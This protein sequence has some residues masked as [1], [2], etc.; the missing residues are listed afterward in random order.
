MS[1]GVEIDIQS[2]HEHFVK[3]TNGYTWTLLSKEDRSAEENIEMVYAANASLYHGTQAGTALHLQ[4][5]GWL[6]AH[7]YTILGYDRAALRHAN[8]CLELA[9]VNLDMMKD[10]DVAY[11]Y[12]GMARALALAG[13]QDKAMSYYEKVRDA[14]ATIGDEEDHSIFI[15]DFESG[16]WYGIG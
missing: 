2:A 7:V 1:E 13:I 8:R 16:D 9:Q 10:F 3:K 12:E 11:G 14:G 15:G 4:R 6:L 5:G